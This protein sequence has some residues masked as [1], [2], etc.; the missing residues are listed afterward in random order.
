LSNPF[1]EF[2]I[3]DDLKRELE[4]LMKGRF[5]NKFEALRSEHDFFNKMTLQFHEK[6]KAPAEAYKAMQKLA[7]FTIYMMI[8][9][10]VGDAKNES[11]SL[12]LMSLLTPVSMMM[13]EMSKSM[14]TISNILDNEVHR[15]TKAHPEILREAKTRFDSMQK[16]NEESV[17]K[18]E[19]DQDNEFAGEDAA[20]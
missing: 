13:N 2:D 6:Y 15:F 14:R 16:Q 12:F 18:F 20:G 5:G 7:S 9:S 19:Q 8:K 4:E 3:P 10:A 17:R 1:D 11:N